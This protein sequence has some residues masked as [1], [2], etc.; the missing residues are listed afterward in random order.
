MN[1]DPHATLLTYLENHAEL[2]GVQVVSGR[3]LPPP[4]WK[5]GEGELVIFNMRGGYPSY[6]GEHLFVSFQMKCYGL[7]ELEAMTV[8][9]KVRKALHYQRGNGVKWAEEEGFGRPGYEMTQWPFVLSFFSVSF[10]N[11]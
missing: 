10:V 4:G 8:Y 9:R 5:P 6:E 1:L 11:A 2:A 3:H 7:T